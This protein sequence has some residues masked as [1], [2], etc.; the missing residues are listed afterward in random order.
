[1]LDS[2]SFTLGHLKGDLIW[3]KNLHAEL[4]YQRKLTNRPIVHYLWTLPSSGGNGYPSCTWSSMVK[5]WKITFIWHAPVQSYKSH[6]ARSVGNVTPDPDLN[7]ENFLRQQNMEGRSAFQSPKMDLRSA[8]IK[9]KIWPH[10][11]IDRISPTK[12]VHIRDRTDGD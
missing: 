1:M 2:T 11:T 3:V 8:T 9:E 5:R 7:S 6:M 4:T 10:L 12:T